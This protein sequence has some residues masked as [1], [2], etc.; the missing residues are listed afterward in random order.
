MNGARDAPLLS[1]AALVEYDGADFHGFQAQTGVPTIQGALEGALRTFTSLDGRIVGAGRTD[2]GVHA[3][4]QVV[5]GRLFWRHDLA[6]L[7][8]AWNAHLPPTIAVRQV[9]QA[10]E[11]FHPRFAASSR[12]YRYF[13][14]QQAL[15]QGAVSRSPLGRCYAHFEQRSLDAAAMQA[16]AQI[17]IGEHDFAAFGRPPQGDSTVRQIFQSEWQQVESTL[18]SLIRNQDLML[19]Y[20]VQANAFLQHMVRNLVG[21]MLAVGRG[22]RTVTDVETTLA[23]RNRMMAPPPAPACGLVLERVEYANSWGI[24]F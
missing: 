1:I 6:A 22:E 17:F 11:G 19:V 5:G 24:V 8:R 9:Q 2:A 13:V 18:A 21:M 16:A 10:P 3:R 15:R 4:G 12:T 14:M 7:Q 23:A 20:T